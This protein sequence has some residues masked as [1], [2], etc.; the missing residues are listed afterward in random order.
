MYAVRGQRTAARAVCR[1]VRT[2]VRRRLRSA[3]PGS[4]REAPPLV[5]ARPRACSQ[6]PAPSAAPRPLARGRGGAFLALWACPAAP[7]RRRR[8][9]RARAE[10]AAA[11]GAEGGGA[12]LPAEPSI[13]PGDPRPF[14]G[15]EQSSGAAG[16]KAEGGAQLAPPHPARRRSGADV[17]WVGGGG[18]ACARWRWIWRGR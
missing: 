2:P 3:G 9:A 12:A 5:R 17:P 14:R 16:D 4:G 8:L 6:D 13:L 10:G 11:R 1:S 18:G 7:P 15:R